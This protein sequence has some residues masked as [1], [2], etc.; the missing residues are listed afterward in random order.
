MFVVLETKWVCFMS[1]KA[2]RVCKNESIDRAVWM[3]TASASNMT[4]DIRW[5]GCQVI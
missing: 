5:S 1:M 2:L 4:L 3:A